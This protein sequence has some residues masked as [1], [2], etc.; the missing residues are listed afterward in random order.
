[1]G[2]PFGRVWC[3]GVRRAVRASLT[4]YGA[5]GHRRGL[6]STRCYIPLH[7]VTQERARLNKALDGL[8]ADLIGMLADDDDDSPP[9]PPPA[10]NRSPNAVLHGASIVNATS[11]QLPSG[12]SCTA[13][14]LT[15][16]PAVLAHPVPGHVAPGHLAPGHVAL[17]HVAP[18]LSAPTTVPLVSPPAHQM[19][20]QSA[21]LAHAAELQQMSQVSAM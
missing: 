7:T 19:I 13:P 12:L 5:R 16:G 10:H 6:A 2:A 4:E 18:A 17:G 14:E 11:G 21:E 9:R 1:M 3:P 20:L 15:L 8:Q